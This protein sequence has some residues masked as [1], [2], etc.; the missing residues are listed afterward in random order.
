MI[1]CIP[2]GEFLLVELELPPNGIILII[3]PNNSMHFTVKSCI[4]SKPGLTNAHNQY[5]RTPAHPPETP[6]QFQLH[7]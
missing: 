5:L 1:N 6:D 7:H 3:I 4:D 2:I